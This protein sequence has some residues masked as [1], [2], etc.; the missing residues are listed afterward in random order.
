[1]LK[2]G[3]KKRCLLRVNNIIPVDR[4]LNTMAPAAIIVQLLL[5][6][7]TR[8]L[9]VNKGNKF[10]ACQRTDRLRLQVIKWRIA[11][12]RKPDEHDPK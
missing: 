11:V 9:G 2:A 1:L 6:A 7:T 10:S 4:A 12:A 5:S 3:L 8:K